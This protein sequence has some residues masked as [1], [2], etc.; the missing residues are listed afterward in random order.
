MTARCLRADIVNGFLTDSSN[1]DARNHAPPASAYALRLGLLGI[2]LAALACLLIASVPGASAWQSGDAYP[3]SGDWII[4]DPTIVAGES[5]VVTG[6][7]DISSSLTVYNSK[8]FIDQSS[9]GQ[10]TLNVASGGKLLFY[11]SLLASYDS[12]DYKFTVYGSLHIN[13][14]EVY[15]MWGDISSWVGGIQLYS[16]S[17]AVIENSYI[18]N[19]KTGGI[20]IN[21]CSPTI[22]YNNIYNNGF[23][24]NEKY[25]YGIYAISDGTTSSLIQY[26]TISNN[27]YTTSSMYYG[28]GLRSESQGINDVILGNTF[29]GNGFSTTGSSYGY[30]IY[31][32][33]SRPTMKDNSF[34]YGQYGIYAESSSPPKITGGSIYTYAR[35][36]VTAYGVYATSS[37]LSFEGVRF[38]NSYNQYNHYAVY[39]SSSKLTF[40]GCTFDFQLSGSTYIRYN[41]YAVSTEVKVSSCL[42][43]NRYVGGYVIYAS[44]SPV[45]VDDSIIVLRDC[46]YD[47]YGIYA[48][49]NSPVFINRTSIDFINFDVLTSSA[50]LTRTIYGV[51]AGSTSPVTSNYLT[52]N[53]TSC[54]AKAQAAYSALLNI[55]GIYGTSYSPLTLSYTTLNLIDTNVSNPSS[56]TSNFNFYGIYGTS[57]SPVKLEYTTLTIR[58]INTTTITTYNTNFYVYGIR[59]DNYSPMTLDNTTITVADFMSSARGGASYY[60]YNYLYLIYPYYLYSEVKMNYTSF[61]LRD[62]KSIT[63]QGYSI[64]YIYCVYSYY[65]VPTVMRYTTIDATRIDS[66]AT[67]TSTV[68][69]YGGRIYIYGVY[70]YYYSPVSMDYTW[71]NFTNVRAYTYSTLYYGYTYVYFYGVYP[72]Q[73]SPLF[74]NYTFIRFVNITAQTYQAG[75]SYP[76][77]SYV[78]VYGLYPY[79]AYEFSRI[80]YNDIFIA[81]IFCN[82][83]TTTYYGYAYLYM[84]PVYLYYYCPSSMNYTKMDIQN[85]YCN[86][87]AGTSGSCYGYTYFYF[88]MLYPYYYSPIILNYTDITI[89]NINCQAT[90]RTYYIY[91]RMY[92]YGIYPYYYTPITVEKMTIRV[93][94][95]NSTSYASTSYYAYS[96]LYFYGPIYYQYYY[97]NGLYNNV[98]ILIEKVTNRAY[99]SSYYTYSYLYIYSFYY[100]YYYSH[101]AFNNLNFT[102][103]DV[104]NIA[105]AASQYCY[106]YMYIYN[107]YY[108]YYSHIS[109]DNSSLNFQDIY[110]RAYQGTTY[111]TAYLYLYYPAGYHYYT[112][113]SHFNNTNIT[114][115]N[116]KA[117]SYYTTSYANSYFYLYYPIYAYYYRELYLRNVNLNFIDCGVNDVSSTYNIFYLY[118]GIYLSSY[119][120]FYPSNFK[121][122]ALNFT[123]NQFYAIYASSLTSLTLD[124]N[125]IDIIMENWKLPA[126]STV[127]IICTSSCNRVDLL[128]MKLRLPVELGGTI[129]G[130]YA[131]GTGATTDYVNITN[132][133][134]FFSNKDYNNANLRPIYVSSTQL[135]MDNTTID[136]TTYRDV[137]I[138]YATSSYGGLVKNC[139]F[140]LN[141]TYILST[142]THSDLFYYTGRSPDRTPFVME[143][144]NVWVW[145]YSPAGIQSGPMLLGGDTGGFSSST[146]IVSKCFFECRNMN[147]LK[148]MRLSYLAAGARLYLNDSVFNFYYGGGTGT[149]PL[150]FSF[151]RTY[152][153]TEVLEFNNT[154]LNITY[155]NEPLTQF[156][157]YQDG[158]MGRIAFINSRVDFKI[159]APGTT[160]SFITFE[161]T[162]GTEPSLNELVVQGSRF[163][164]TATREECKLSLLGLTKSGVVQ[165]L[166]LSNSEF[167]LT[168]E[169]PSTLPCSGVLLVGVKGITISDMKVF[170]NAPAGSD[171][172]LTGVKLE[173]SAGRIQNITVAG[174]GNGRAYG[175]HCDMVS[176][177]EI[178][179]CSFS[180]LYAAIYSTYFSRPMVSSKITDCTYGFL[181]ESSGNGTL[182]GCTITSCAYGANVSDE[183][184]V[185]LI[186]SSIQ[187]TTADLQLSGV[188]TV[189]SLNSTFN[190]AR[191]TYF[192]DKS[193]V[194]INWWLGIKVTWQNGR[195]VP[196]ADVIAKDNFG[197]EVL[198]T[199]CT[200]SGLVP[201]FSVVEYTQTRLATRYYTPYTLTASK[202]GFTGETKVVVDRTMEATVVIVDDSLPVVVIFEPADDTFQNFTTVTLVGIA[203]DIG[204]GMEKLSLSYDGV[205]WVD[206]P[207]AGSWLYV[208]E[209]VPEGVWSITAKV[210]DIAG[211]E[212]SASVRV[213]IDLT[214][215]F[216]VV[217]SPACD[218][219]GN[220][221]AVNLVGRVEPGSTLTINYLPASVGA[222]GSF[223]FPLRLVEGRNVYFLFA[224]DRSGNTN[225]T[226]WVLNLDITPPVLRLTSPPDG[227]LTRVASV[228]VSGYTEP[229]ATLL[230]N[231]VRREL[232]ADGSFSFELGLSP[233]P[234]LIT[235]VSSDGVGNRAIIKRTV[236]LDN[237]IRLTVTSPENNSITNQ[238]TL[239]VQG[240]TDTDV[241]L[242]MNGGLVTIGPDGSFSLTCTL[243]EGVNELLFDGVDRAGNTIKLVR[244]ITLDTTRPLVRILEPYEGQLI[245]SHR[246]TVRGTCEAGMRLALNGAAVDTSG[247]TFTSELELP[248]GPNVIRVEGSDAAGNTVALE[249]RVLV[250]TLAPPLELIEP[251]EGFRTS[252][253]SVT[254]SGITEP[255]ARVTVNGVP[256]LVDAEGKFST[257]QTMRR[258]GNTVTVT[259]MDGAGNQVNRTVKLKVVEKPAGISEETSWVWTA[260]GLLAAL[261]IM[262]PLTTLLL[263]I[264]LRIHR[265]QTGG[266]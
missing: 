208:M 64:V 80:N 93:S 157:I 45:S 12:Y 177:P 10:Y 131:S 194:I 33:S 224:K 109:L 182:K 240:T 43:N 253:L 179:D 227:L 235:V 90:A 25:A 62:I 116:L 155:D 142:L 2:F 199:V 35:A 186:D 23:G 255:G 9:D 250:D 57:Y 72:Q 188:S 260:S 219:W 215:P 158:P 229:G 160:Q 149:F 213:T 60:S 248:D 165:S 21:R 108:T 86:A 106:A 70:S 145:D 81:N 167:N 91:S 69:S 31:L 137:T 226:S 132:A 223:S 128:N 111:S 212:A 26:N 225:S 144:C 201:P 50:A 214:P 242:R 263:T 107:L 172:A 162:S 139:N 7:I 16:T 200:E 206:L 51:Y 119:A 126:S 234:N 237:E 153:G 180:H 141:Y 102:I 230:V 103:R 27:Y 75:G 245:P 85:F 94:N 17:S 152:P 112:G 98:T 61:Y 63:Q 220:S 59:T 66:I 42:F 79:Y 96:Y 184:W 18:A 56:S 39:A 173:R 191:V 88:Y 266:A 205:S 192:D 110:C 77:Y 197:T 247:G 114:F 97:G 55:Y 190:K 238:I 32:S 195:P 67:Q 13:E 207:P 150:T 122:Y 89:N 54:D 68:Y 36:S 265:R 239:L 38:S 28:Y 217:E 52:L 30:Q 147:G 198:R 47:S 174:N 222:D 95:L 183:S 193:T 170:L 138:I 216:I 166:S 44:S 29:S 11:Q 133:T 84:Y 105:Y 264:G 244:I 168:L 117:C 189:W 257:V 65:Y 15:D 49:S 104:N 37:T 83:T 254:V 115:R 53:F 151:I 101:T 127:Y 159:N 169:K 259:A 148:S 175:I 211:N 129:Y 124:F 196:S 251:V 262:I 78:Y 82:L 163:S 218:S 232:E 58:F 76:S 146:F 261:G 41:I 249:L 185:S 74:T 140:F 92:F 203:S 187:A 20:Y 4:D 24:G 1:P 243:Q 118:Y 231:D 161:S 136:M 14:S 22:Q 120:T 130:V 246:V 228:L 99:A 134:L 143:N 221:I 73:Y 8:I 100:M 123:G 40:Y 135:Y 87:T 236:V 252:E 233:G 3:G 46:T 258:G 19:G 176:W 209:N 71:M 5:L 241:S 178:T 156:L 6:K 125:S 164:M 181:A 202:A 256:V 121:I 34:Y 210:T 171:M 154:T 48:T 204:S 113:Q